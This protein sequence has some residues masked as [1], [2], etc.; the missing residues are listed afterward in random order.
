MR[1]NENIIHTLFLR[2][3][4]NSSFRILQE[5]VALRHLKELALS[6]CNVSN[7]LFTRLKLPPGLHALYLDYNLLTND[8]VPELCAYARRNKRLKFISLGK[9]RIEDEG[10]RTLT[11]E[12]PRTAVAGLVLTGNKFELEEGLALLAVLQ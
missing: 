9:N 12:L 10:V 3:I 11:E 1:K 2:S 8:A 4:D 7:K 5:A 6:R